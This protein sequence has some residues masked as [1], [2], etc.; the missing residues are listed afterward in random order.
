[1]PSPV[2]HHYPAFR[3]LL[4]VGAGC[5]LVILLLAPLGCSFFRAPSETREVAIEPRPEP[6]PY[7]FSTSAERRARWKRDPKTKS[8]KPAEPPQR[9]QNPANPDAEASSTPQPPAPKHADATM[10]NVLEPDPVVA[11]APVRPVDP[12]RRDEVA[13]LYREVYLPA[14]NTPI[15]WQGS[16][17]RCDAGTQ[18]DESTE[19]ARQLVNYYRTMAGLRGDIVFDP[20]LNAKCRRAALSFVATPGLSHAIPPG[21]TCYSR[22]GNEAAGNSNIALGYAGPIAV[23]K[24]MEE[25]WEKGFNLR[26]RQWILYSPTKLMG[27]GSVSG[28]N[29]RINGYTGANALW[30][31]PKKL[32]PKS[33]SLKWVAWPPRGYVPYPV[34]FRHWSLAPHIDGRID[35]RKA[36]VTMRRENGEVVNVQRGVSTSPYAP[37]PA[38]AWIPEGLNFGPGMRDETFNIEV[39]NVGIGG[40]V[41]SYRYSVTVIDPAT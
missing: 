14:V 9:E 10:K 4:R 34:V 20:V 5:F 40:S 17:D 33:P 1:M 8:T 39:S 21:W 29:E 36:K 7:D 23:E 24:Y 19:A 41:R 18:S 13:K 22:D 27:S 11:A 15:T 12:M 28:G 6:T 37:D 31:M 16:I 35:L 25:P 30:V 32:G 3:F 38:L 26:H 2:L